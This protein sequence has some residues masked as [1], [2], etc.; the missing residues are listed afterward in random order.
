MKTQ[1]FTKTPY[2]ETVH[3]HRIPSVDVSVDATLTSSS[4]SEDEFNTA[5]PSTIQTQYP[6]HKILSQQVNQNVGWVDFQRSV[7]KHVES[8]HCLIYLGFARVCR[9]FFRANQSVHTNANLHSEG[10]E[11]WGIVMGLSTRTTHDARTCT[12]MPNKSVA[13]SAS[14]C[15]VSLHWVL[16]A[17]ECSRFVVHC[18]LSTLAWLRVLFAQCTV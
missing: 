8:L 3:V 2:V 14:A 10:V 11:Y 5:D 15:Q 12:L 18:V 4:T 13:L 9:H 1:T 16:N 7:K 6:K 17:C